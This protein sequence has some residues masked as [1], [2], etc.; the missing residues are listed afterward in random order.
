MMRYFYAW[1]P[2]AFVGA[3]VVLSLPWLGLLAVVILPLL[4]LAALAV[5]LVYFPLVFGRAIQHHRQSR[6]GARRRTVAPVSP[7]TRQAPQRA[8]HHESGAYG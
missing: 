6:S 3:V 2:P 1:T 8:P 4:T 5:P 7:V